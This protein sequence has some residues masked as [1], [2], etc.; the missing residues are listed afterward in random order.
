MTHA[1]LEGLAGDLAERGIATLRY[2]FPFMQGGRH[3]PDRP[4][5]AHAAVRGAVAA[6]NR[7]AGD[8]PL[9]AGGRSY[10]GRMTS[11]AQAVSPLP[12]VLGLVFFAF[13][14]HPAG[15]PSTD[16]GRHL[17]QVQVPLL[18]LQGT[19]DA[20]ADVAL[21]QQLCAELGERA[22]LKL[23]AHADH[24]F[25]VFARSGRTDPEV[26]REMLDA[27]VSWAEEFMIKR[28][29][30]AASGLEEPGSAPLYR[31][32]TRAAR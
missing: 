1:S 8:L 17:V 24:S 22:T 4:A 16:R 7:V 30:P 28:Q 12:G 18:F 13:P 15:R 25:R 27:V 9:F 10:G 11:Q 21:L 19:R 6:A 26:R 3:R 29:E 23:L 31:S 2:E 5:L 14:L 32:T 20:L